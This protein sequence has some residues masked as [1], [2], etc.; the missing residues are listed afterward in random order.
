M[1]TRAALVLAA[2]IL[3]EACASQDAPVPRQAAT[4]PAANKCVVG[5]I[6]D[7]DSFE[8]S[9]G[10]RIRLLLVDS[11]ELAQG[12]S[13]DSAKKILTSLMPPGTSVRLEFDID[14]EDQYQRTLAYVYRDKL[15]INR[16]MARRG[17]ALVIVFQ[18]NVKMVDVI[19][20][21][22]DSARRERRGL[23]KTN[24]FDCKPSDFR[25]RRCG[26]GE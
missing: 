9:N 3:S 18:P 22:V 24:A 23:W 5:R 20:A 8:C 26:A 17:F 11:P 12:K 15:F 10:E 7:G 16:E 6:A 4:I 21:A 1:V 25:A 19:R 13:G 14:R 2:L